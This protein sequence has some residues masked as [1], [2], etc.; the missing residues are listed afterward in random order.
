MPLYLSEPSA[1]DVLVSYL[2]MRMQWLHHPHNFFVLGGFLPTHSPQGLVER[3][4]LV[5]QDSCEC[6]LGRRGS[7]CCRRAGSIKVPFDFCHILGHRTSVCSFP[8][9]RHHCF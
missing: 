8:L 6:F 5:S 3:F 4:K 9:I 1:L 2:A 7:I